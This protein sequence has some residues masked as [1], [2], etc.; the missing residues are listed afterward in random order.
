MKIVP[1]PKSNMG[2]H[3]KMTASYDNTTGALNDYSSDKQSCL[4]DTSRY[5]AFCTPSVPC[6]YKCN[7]LPFF[8][9]QVNYLTDK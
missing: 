3:G 6:L 9:P 4:H 1:V 2:Y 5:C 8:L 7:D